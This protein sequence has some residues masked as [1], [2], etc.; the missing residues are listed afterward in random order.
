MGFVV[1]TES[2][3]RASAYFKPYG[4]THSIRASHYIDCLVI[5]SLYV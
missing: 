3:L 4:L 5:V 1:S 2:A